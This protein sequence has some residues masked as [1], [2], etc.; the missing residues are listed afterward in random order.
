MTVFNKIS[1]RFF[2]L[3]HLTLRQLVGRFSRNVLPRIQT[4]RRKKHTGV[5]RKGRLNPKASWLFHDAWNNTV[6][7]HNGRFSFLGETSGF[8]RPVSWNAS[9]HTLLWRFWLHAFNYLYLLPREEQTKLCYEWIAANP[10]GSQPGWHPYPL[11]RRIINWCKVAL[12]DSEISQSIYQQANYLSQTIETHLGGNHLLENARALILVGRYF[13]GDN[14]ADKWLQKGLLIFEEETK[15]QILADGWHYERSPMY[16]ALMLEGYL[17]ILNLLSNNQEPFELINSTARGMLD[18]L[19]SATRPDGQIVLF[20]DAAAE[21][22]PS[23]EKLVEYGQALLGYEPQYRE[24]FPEAG[25]YTYRD[26]KLFI[27]IDGGEIGPEELPAHAH[28]DIFSYELGLYGLPFVVDTGVYEYEE[29]EMRDYVRH[30]RAHNTVCVDGVSQAE[31][32]KSFRVARRYPPKEVSYERQDAVR[33][34]HGIFDGYRYLIGDRIQ[35]K[36]TIVI[37]PK[38]HRVSIDDIIYGNGRHLVESR[39]HLHP[40][41]KTVGKDSVMELKRFNVRATVSAHG[42]SLYQEYGFYCPRMGSCLKSN[43]LTLTVETKLPIH[44]GYTFSY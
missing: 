20:N 9:Q 38:E 15:K 5:V 24:S 30:T 13:A 22:A 21:I 27:F 4:L 3:R 2:T 33:T 16:H 37:D 19:V 31:C 14:R 36:R 32:W 41:T 11:S 35:H 23:T 34:F 40:Q 7:L 10:I 29:G 26:E 43:T 18:A 28:A 1:L 12:H 8:G 6:A 25:Y 39:I 44:F 17:D 42:A